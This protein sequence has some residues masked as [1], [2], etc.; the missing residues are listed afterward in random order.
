MTVSQKEMVKLK[1]LWPVEKI[2]EKDCYFYNIPIEKY[3][4]TTTVKVK[5]KGEM[6]M[7]GGYSYLSLHKNKKIEKKT[8]QALEKFGTGGHGARLLAGTTKIHRELEKKISVFKETEDAITYSSGY[9]A[10]ISSISSLVGRNDTIIADRKSHASITDGGVLSRA[11]VRR[12]RHNDMKHL[13]RMLKQNNPGRVLV[14]ADS[15]FS[16][17]GDIFDLP[18][19]SWLCKKYGALL[20]MDES[21]SIGV[22]GK[23]GKGIE[24]HYGLPKNT[25]DI[26]MGTLSKAIPSQGGYIATSKMLCNFL[27][28]QS[29]GFIYSG[30]NTPTNDAASI[31]AIDVIMNEP[32]RVDKLHENV[33]YA[34][35]K[36]N[37]NG[38][39]TLDST[40]AILPVVCGADWRALELAKHCHDNNIY[41]QAIPYPVVPKGKARLRLSINTDHTKEQID[42]LAEVLKG[43]KVTSTESF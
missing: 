34:K 26:K 1:M 20:M 17:D 24:E 10:N 42:Y 16:M 27:R 2:K 4:S 33:A 29:R 40:T 31:A 25:I 18:K 36:L 22:I 41:I 39:D 28:H 30:A 14:I 15:I 9:V 21:H 35:A 23:T 8:K 12:F 32:E 43:A 38:I 5:E 6:I 19:A 3:L 7:F 37:A 11:T 13:E